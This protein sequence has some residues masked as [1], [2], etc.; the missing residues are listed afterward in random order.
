MAQCKKAVVWTE[1]SVSCF[2][3]QALYEGMQAIVLADPTAVGA[4]VEIILPHF[5]KYFEVNENLSPPLKLEACAAL[6]VKLHLVCHVTPVQNT[7]NV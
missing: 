4:L 7:C 5:I 3:L 2:C 1:A 6:Q